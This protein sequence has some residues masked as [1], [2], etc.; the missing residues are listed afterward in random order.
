MAVTCTG[1]ALAA[2]AVDFDRLSDRELQVAQTYLLAK[3]ANSLN[4]AIATDA[5]SVQNL[6]AAF[7]GVSDRALAEA[8]VALLCQL[9]S[10]LGV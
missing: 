8:Q 4:S 10:V 3:M 6:A 7:S 2:A 5:K 1:T 9:A